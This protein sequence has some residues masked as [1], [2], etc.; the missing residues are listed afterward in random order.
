MRN[1][2]ISECFSQYAWLILVLDR[3]MFDKPC[4]LCVLAKEWRGL[5]TI[6]LIFMQLTVCL[7]LLAIEVFVLFGRLVSSKDIW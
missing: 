5:G 7:Y 4:V 2:E 3:L 1:L 6:I